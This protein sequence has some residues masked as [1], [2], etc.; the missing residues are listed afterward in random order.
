MPLDGIPGTS[1]W[2][3]SLYSPRSQGW[4][5]FLSHM[6]TSPQAASILGHLL[7][8]RPWPGDRARGQG[9]GLPQGCEDHP[10]A[11]PPLPQSFA[12]QCLLQPMR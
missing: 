3:G 2:R 11:L 12:N 8:A 9:G 1:F 7:Y 10:P 6:Q 4:H 5:C